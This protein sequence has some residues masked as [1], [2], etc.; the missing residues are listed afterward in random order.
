MNAPTWIITSV[1]SEPM[2]LLIGVV[3]EWGGG[4]FDTSQRVVIEVR[5]TPR[6]ILFPLSETWLDYSVETSI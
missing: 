6:G 2:F 5:P 3:E 1:L 4:A